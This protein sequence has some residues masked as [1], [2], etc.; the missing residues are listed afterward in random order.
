MTKNQKI[1]NHLTL[2]NAK[3]KFELDIATYTAVTMLINL[4]GLAAQTDKVLLENVIGHL[5]YPNEKPSLQLKLRESWTPEQIEDVDL[6]LKKLTTITREE[7][8]QSVVGL[9]KYYL[10]LPLPEMVH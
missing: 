7:Q 10:D 1:I 6:F 3:L 9:F 8:T 5:M 2:E 4:A